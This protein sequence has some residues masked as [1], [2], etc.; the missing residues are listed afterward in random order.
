[1]EFRRLRYNKQFYDPRI[2][3]TVKGTNL[4]EPEL[5][6]GKNEC[7]FDFYNAI[8][9][10]RLVRKRKIDVRSNDKDAKDTK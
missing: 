2:S 3:I 1:M 10:T 6:R 9:H 4:S 8:F 5:V 7:N